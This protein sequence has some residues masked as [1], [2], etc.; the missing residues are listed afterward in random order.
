MFKFMRFALEKR[1]PSFE[2]SDKPIMKDLKGKQLQKSKRSCCRVLLFGLRAEKV[3]LV[4]RRL[5]LL[6]WALVCL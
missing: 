1:R 6:V 3:V 4:F 5:R 2:L